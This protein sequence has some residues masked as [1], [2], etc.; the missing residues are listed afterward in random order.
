MTRERV[1]KDIATAEFQGTS[2]TDSDGLEALLGEWVARDGRRAWEQDGDDDAVLALSY[3]DDEPGHQVIAV[4]RFDTDAVEAVGYGWS[5]AGLPFDVDLPPA[6]SG[7]YA[8]TVGDLDGTPDA[9][10]WI[11]AG[12]VLDACEVQYLKSLRL[13]P[14]TGER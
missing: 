11:Q 8:I 10:D 9:A 1:T 13:P 3:Y 14:P 2:F 6:P 12:H 4:I 5:L 7:D